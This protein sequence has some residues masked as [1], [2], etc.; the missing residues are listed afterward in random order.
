VRSALPEGTRLSVDANGGWSLADAKQMAEW[1]AER[2]IDHLEQPLRRGAEEELAELRA[3]SQLP[4]IL[5]E[6]VLD[7]ADIVR[8]HRMAALDGINIK[9]MK[10]GGVT[11]ALR[12]VATAR[13]HGLKILVGCYGHTALGNTAAAALAP[14]VDYLDLDSHLNL[15]DDPFSGS[16]Y[17]DGYLH[18]PA[19]VGFG[20]S[21]ATASH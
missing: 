2:G 11:E 6:S 5:D 7:S 12:M 13:A 14:L 20:I 4:V 15:K 16:E 10:C 9:L 19:G 1:L 17:R 8:L 3:Q 18:P 21:H